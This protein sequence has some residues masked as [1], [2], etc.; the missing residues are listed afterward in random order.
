[1]GATVFIGPPKRIRDSFNE[2]EASCEQS[3][4]MVQRVSEEG[5]FF[6]I[7]A[8]TAYLLV[9]INALS[10]L[11]MDLLLLGPVTQTSTVPLSLS[12]TSICAVLILIWTTEP[13]SFGGKYG[14]SLAQHCQVYFSD[15][16]KL[17]SCVMSLTLL[18]MPSRRHTA[19]HSCY[20]TT[21]SMKQTFK[22]TVFIICAFISLTGFSY[23]S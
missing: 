22:F 18:C 3:E 20:I 6:G 11:G 8:T 12:L 7:V 16:G 2:V 10:S 17:R 21:I 15:M 23:K 1:M 4:Y 5:F 13:M 9:A 14:C 19:S